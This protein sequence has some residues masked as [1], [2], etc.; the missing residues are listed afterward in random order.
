VYVEALSGGQHVTVPNITDMPVSDASMILAERGLEMGKQT[1]VP[2]QSSPKYS[3]V[4]Q[5]PAPGRVVRTGRKVYPTVSMGADFLTAPNLV[6]QHIEEARANI[7]KA[8]S[9]YRIGTVARVPNAAARDTVLAQDPPAGRNMTNQGNIHLLVSAGQREQGQFMPDIRGKQ[10]DQMLQEMAKFG[11][12][13]V[14]QEVNIPGAKPNVVIDQDPP[15]DTLIYPGQ[16][17]TYMIKA[18]GAETTEPVGETYTGE[19]AHVMSYDWFD[20]AVRVDLIDYQ[21]NKTVLW[22]APAQFDDSSRRQRAAGSTIRIPVTYTEEATV[23]VYVDGER[24]A[25]YR[26]VEGAAPVS[27]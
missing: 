16:L 13:P 4:A 24:T 2:H 18:E 22:E 3:V 6:G 15:P 9:R 8:A 5:R 23:E 11:V 14:A 7:R 12:T 25:R 17:V 21:G 27:Q 19:V 1:H 26:L 10:V 20:R